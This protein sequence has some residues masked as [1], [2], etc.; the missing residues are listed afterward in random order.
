[1]PCVV[2]TALNG[3]T[4]YSAR[5]QAHPAAS[6]GIRA[7]FLST[8]IKSRQTATLNVCNG[9]RNQPSR[10]IRP[11]VR[12]CNSSGTICRRGWNAHECTERTTGRARYASV[13]LHFLPTAS[14]PFVRLVTVV[15][16]ARR[17]C[18]H[19]GI[20]YTRSRSV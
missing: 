5:M 20:K 8:A 2:I 4:V 7:H 15:G 11:A 18:S 3:V 6:Y 19:T 10:A 12:H 13:C 9:G 16:C 14:F 1:M 17:V